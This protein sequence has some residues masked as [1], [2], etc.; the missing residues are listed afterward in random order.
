M[1][2]KGDYVELVK[3]LYFMRID[4]D[5]DHT[6]SVS[7]YEF[8]SWETDGTPCETEKI[9]SAYVKFDGSIHMWM[10]ESENY[11]Y[12]D[13]MKEYCKM[14][15]AFSQICLNLVSTDKDYITD[16]LKIVKQELQ[17]EKREFIEYC[18]RENENSKEK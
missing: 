11:T 6:I 5:I 10:G 8:V 2:K 4:T 16:N 9:G 15:E 18:S 12:L 14:L 3:N 17:E 7:M 13:N 1:F